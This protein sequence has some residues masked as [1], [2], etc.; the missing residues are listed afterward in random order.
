MLFNLCQHPALRALREPPF[1]QLYE[2][3]NVDLPYVLRFSPLS[4]IEVLH[5]LL[6]REDPVLTML[7]QFVHD[8]FET[9]QVAPTLVSL[10]PIRYQR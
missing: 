9:V 2:N 5:V 1:H 7:V 10:Y 4:P 3:H 6:H 8:I